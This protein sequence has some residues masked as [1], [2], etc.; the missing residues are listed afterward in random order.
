QRASE[1]AEYERSAPAIVHGRIGDG[2]YEVRAR[3]FSLLKAINAHLGDR[4]TD[5]G[6]EREISTEVER[7]AN[8][9]FQGIAVPD[10]YFHV[11]KRVLTIGSAAADLYPTSLRPD[12]FIDAL[13][14][15]LIVGQL[16]ATVLD[17]LVGT[18]DIPKQTGSSTAQWLAEEDSLS[19]DDASFTDVSLAP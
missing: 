7:R 18:V 1:L 15:R 6:F 3:D 16:G 12:L 14:A 17:G 5:A 11:E 4:K 8:R 10:E 2:Q 9:Q 19:A 13:R